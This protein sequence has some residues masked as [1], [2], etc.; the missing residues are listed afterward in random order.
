[1]VGSL[2]GEV[3]GLVG[4][5]VGKVFGLAGEVVDEVS[6]PR[7]KDFWVLP[8]GVGGLWLGWARLGSLGWAVLGS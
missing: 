5:I 6:G 1:V 3:R 7:R 4:E 2:V 8:G